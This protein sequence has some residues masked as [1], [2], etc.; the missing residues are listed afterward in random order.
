MFK[1]CAPSSEVTSLY[2]LFHG[3]FTCSQINIGDHRRIQG[4]GGGGGRGDTAPPPPLVKKAWGLAPPPPPLIS[5]NKKNMKDIINSRE[6]QGDKGPDWPKTFHPR[7]VPNP[8][9]SYCKIC[10]LPIIQTLEHLV[11]KKWKKRFPNSSQTD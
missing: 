6:F 8:S 3:N 2:V 9:R 4:G 1:H 7:D 5:G 11:T 10:P